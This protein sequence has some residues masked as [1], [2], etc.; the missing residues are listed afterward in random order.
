MAIEKEIESLPHIKLTLESMATWE[1]WEMVCHMAGANPAY[2]KSVMLY[3]AKADVA[4]DEA[5]PRSTGLT[6]K[7]TVTF[8]RWEG[9]YARFN[10]EAEFDAC[11]ALDSMDD[12]M[13]AQVELGE[14]YTLDEVYK[15]A[16]RLGQ[17]HD[18][19]GPFEVDLD[20]DNL[21]DYLQARREAR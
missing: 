20:E 19:D 10:G 4:K 7:A 17:I 9:D 21:S 12:D 16:V 8:Q 15:T 1:D 18:Y 13:I 11:D 14:P 5:R 3:V 6:V 2:T